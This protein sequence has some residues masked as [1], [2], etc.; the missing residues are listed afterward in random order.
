MFTRFNWTLLSLAITL[1]GLAWI[2]QSREAVVVADYSNLATAPQA[3]YLAP[4]FTLT[5]IQG[6]ER[7]LSNYRGRPVILNFWATWCPPCRAEIPFF[8]QS[9]LKYNGRAII[10]GIDQAEPLSLVAPFVAELA[11]T[12]PILLDLE[13][14]VSDSYRVIA[15]PT[16]FFI[17]SNGVLQKVHPGII[18]Q[19]VLEDE[20]EKLLEGQ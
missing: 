7:T 18:S 5:T 3:G 6:E 11:M 4:D 20:I 10:W 15:L 12:Y 13:S 8:Q 16:T 17:D 9:Q 2:E 1:L 14:E 19:G